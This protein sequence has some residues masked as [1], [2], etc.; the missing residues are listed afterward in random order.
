MIR[1]THQD[2]IE[3]RH[4]PT[5]GVVMTVNEPS[6][7][8]VS[9]ASW[10]VSTG[11]TEVRIYFDKPRD[12][13]MHAVAALPRV[14]VVECNDKYWKGLRLE[15]PQAQTK[16][17]FINANH[18]LKGCSVDWLAHI[19]ADEFLF[20]SSPIENE[21]KTI[22]LMNAALHFDVRE[23][24]F[25]DSCSIS[26]IFDGVFRA[27]SHLP[28]ALDPEIFGDL[29]RYLQRGL[30]SHCAGKVAVPT[31]QDLVLGIHSAYCGRRSSNT[32]ARVVQSKS[33][34]LLHFDGLTPLHWF[35]KLL[36]YAGATQQLGTGM[37]SKPRQYQIKECLESAV[38][39][40]AL[41]AFHNKLRVLNEAQRLCHA[42]Y[43]LLHEGR[44][45]PSGAIQSVYSMPMDLSP[46]AFDVEL[47]ARESN[48]PEAI[49]CQPIQVPIHNSDS[50]SK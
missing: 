47:L 3:L 14:T 26:S 32:K 40:N 29:N 13:V 16:R 34:V 7:L 42:S 49:V 36:R 30:L 41:V 12:P 10:H 8:V 25:T 17:Q 33:T 9:N 18:A 38:N 39:H 31:K 6:A 45:D 19:D 24:V 5:W 43:G 37:F 35:A 48:I 44:F 21:L 46:Q 2:S 50:L 28:V 11:A 1:N 15:R 27:R 22:H 4:G 20:Q 23:R